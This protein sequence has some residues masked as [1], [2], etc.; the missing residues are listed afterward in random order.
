MGLVIPLLGETL[1]SVYGAEETEIIARPALHA[2]SLTIVVNGEPMAFKAPYPDD[3]RVALE[4]L[5]R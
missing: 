3:F 1:Y 4:R 5:N 2:Y